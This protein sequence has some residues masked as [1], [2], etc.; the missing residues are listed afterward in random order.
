MIAGV[1]IEKW[2]MWHKP[3]PFRVFV[4][5]RLG[6]DMV[7]LCTKFDDSSFSQ[8]RDIIEGHKISNTSRHLDHVL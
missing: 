2:I 4:I 5:L 7:Y 8:S 6:Y 3:R 1:K